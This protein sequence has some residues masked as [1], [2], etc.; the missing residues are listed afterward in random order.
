MG[1]KTNRWIVINATTTISTNFVTIN[2]P[3]PVKQINVKSMANHDNTTSYTK[4]TLALHSSLINEG[5]ITFFT[6][7]TSPFQFLNGNVLIRHVFTNP[8]SVQGSYRFYMKD[9]TGAFVPYAASAITSFFL[10]LEFCE[11][12]D[13]Q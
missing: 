11:D 6:T 7:N 1:I 10:L 12:C 3:H 4:T 9:L 13:E 8:I 5:C 2:I